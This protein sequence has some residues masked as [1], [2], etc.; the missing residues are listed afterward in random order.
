MSKPMAAPVMQSPLYPFGLVAR[1]KAID[2]SCGVWANEVPLL[3]YISLRGDASNAG[4]AEGSSK[5]LGVT[6]P[7]E[8]CTLA[9]S[10][11]TTVL[12]LSPDE[13]MIVTPRNAHSAVLNALNQSLASIRSQVAGNS[14][15][16]TQVIVQGPN[17]RDVLS[18]CTVYDLD[19]LSQGRVVGTTFGK[20]SLYLRRAGDG[21]CLL[22]R[23]SFADY[24]WRYLE[25]A[26]EPYGFGVAKLAPGLGPGLGVGS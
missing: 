26:A 8:P 3:G 23:R 1:A 9:Q 24:I 15:G 11:D 18:H 10:S 17:A 12:W 22:L 4:F 21:Y 20:S 25:R 7:T 16:Y 6:L 2:A 5:A 13:W 19:R 14:G